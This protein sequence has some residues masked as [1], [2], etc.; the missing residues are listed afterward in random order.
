MRS[1]LAAS[2][3][4]MALT[5][6]GLAGAAAAAPRRV[7]VPEKRP[8]LA[9]AL[10]GTWDGAVISDAR[11]SSHNPVRLVLTR[12]GRNLIQVD[13]DYPRIAT[14]QIPLS[15]A[16]DAILSA[17]PKYTVFYKRGRPNHLDLSLD[18]ATW[19]GDRSQ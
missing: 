10:A 15:A 12:V 2:M 1:I 18:D 14:S 19:A 13:S 6:A 17:T 11:G 8:D 5:G 16:S 3:I 9:D 4:A 7:A